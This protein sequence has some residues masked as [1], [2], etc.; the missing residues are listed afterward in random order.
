MRAYSCVIHEQTLCLSPPGAG[1]TT[2][3]YRE[4]LRAYSKYGNAE[5]ARYLL[6]QG[7]D[8]AYCSPRTPHPLCE[9]ARH[10]HEAIVDMLL[11]AGADPNL[12]SAWGKHDMTK[13]EFT[14]PLAAGASGGS[15]AIVRKLLARGARQKAEDSPL[16]LWKALRLEHRA[17][18]NLLLSLQP[19]INTLGV[20]KD[21]QSVLLLPPFVS[22]P[23]SPGF[24]RNT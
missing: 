7:A 11:A 1:I 18:A 16:A 3:T 2:K 13:Y 10:G 15:L 24:T 6:D 9:A 5:I 22:V 19:P 23:Y 12:V 8:V 4:L 21:P 20:L 17:M 14:T